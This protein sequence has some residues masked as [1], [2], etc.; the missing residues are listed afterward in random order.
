MGVLAGQ[1]LGVENETLLNLAGGG[2][3]AQRLEFRAR[4]R[5]AADPVVGATIS[6]N[7]LPSRALPLRHTSGTSGVAAPPGSG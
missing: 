2:F 1:T 4:S 3:I 5:R 7:V 6:L